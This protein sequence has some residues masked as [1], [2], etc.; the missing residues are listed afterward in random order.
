MNAVLGNSLNFAACSLVPSLPET[1]L[2]CVLPACLAT[3]CFTVALH[4]WPSTCSSSVRRRVPA[5]NTDA[6][7]IEDMAD[8]VVEAL[9]LPTLTVSEVGVFSGHGCGG[10]SS[11]KR[12]QFC[13]LFVGARGLP[14]MWDDPMLLCLPTRCRQ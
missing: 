3:G 11:F 10:M 9:A 8:M 14:H 5:L 13:L 12:R 4:A 6:A 7:F 1:L 2:L